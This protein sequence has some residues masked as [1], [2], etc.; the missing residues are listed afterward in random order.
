MHED[1][2]MIQRSRRLKPQ[3][4]QFS[5]AIDGLPQVKYE[6]PITRRSF[7]ALRQIGTELQ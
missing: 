4:L 5:A 1:R 7:E 3:Y 6:G 2:A